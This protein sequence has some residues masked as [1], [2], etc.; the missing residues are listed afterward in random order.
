MK[1]SAKSRANKLDYHKL[2]GFIKSLYGYPDPISTTKA[3][4]STSFIQED[5]KSFIFSTSFFSPNYIVLFGPP[6]SL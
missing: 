2:E 4:L 5:T 6:R 3:I 1:K